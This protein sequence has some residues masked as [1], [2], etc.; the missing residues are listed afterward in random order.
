MSRLDDLPPDQKAALSLLLRR[1]QSYA[2]LAAV[3][4][5]S[6][7]AVHDRA[8][9]GLATL[10]PAQARA[11]SAE[12]RERIGDFLLGQQ[13]GDDE[14]AGT[15]LV[16]A[17]SPDARAWAQALV[18]ELAP[19]GDGALPTIPTDDDTA[20]APAR[21]PSA[22]LTST[23]QA[24]PAEAAAPARTG[25][26]PQLPVSR[27]AGAILLAVLLIP[28]GGSSPKP[29]AASK[30]PASRGQAAST[31]GAT[32]TQDKRIVMRPVEAGSKAI[33]VA[34]VLSE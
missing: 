28:S 26:R 6:E 22:P 2:D 19:I 12:E 8:H 24:A 17:S 33:G 10:A 31:S 16:L 23:P 13:H 32:P 20:A 29:A 4:D 3:L 1:R 11:L 7:R 15:L 25:G 27:T 34:L 9:A 5:I 18:S 30:A 21:A 14:R